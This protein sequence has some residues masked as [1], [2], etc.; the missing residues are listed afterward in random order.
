MHGG[1]LETAGVTDPQAWSWTIYS[2]RSPL[3]SGNTCACCFDTSTAT[4][5]RLTCKEAWYL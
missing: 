4:F 2:W 5:L 1:P 3:L